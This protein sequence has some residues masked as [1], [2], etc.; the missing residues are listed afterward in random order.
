MEINMQRQNRRETT[1]KHRRVQRVVQVVRI[2]H[3]YS[4]LKWKIN[5]ISKGSVVRVHGYCCCGESSAGSLL[6]GGEDDKR[7]LSLLTC[8]GLSIYRFLSLRFIFPSLSQQR[9][10][11]PS[12]HRR[13][14]V[15]SPSLHWSFTHFNPLHSPLHRSRLSS[16]LSLPPPP[17]R[18]CNR[19]LSSLSALA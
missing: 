10:M 8:G 9:R 17:T 14:L 11:F 12:S 16:P 13:F 18:P 15:R 4:H 7:F 1:R 3:H 5:R 19:L 2:K 6:P